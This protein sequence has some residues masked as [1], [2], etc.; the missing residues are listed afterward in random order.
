MPQLRR[1]DVADI[2][3]DLESFQA[4]FDFDFSKEGAR[5]A[6]DRATSG[7]CRTALL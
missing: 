1:D 6:P 3:D 7:S 5:A 2:F 4:W